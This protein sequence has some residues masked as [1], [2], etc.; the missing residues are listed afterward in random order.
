VRRPEGF[1][2]DL[3]NAIAKEMGLTVDF[4]SQKFDTLIRS[5]RLAERLT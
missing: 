2:V 1:D 5:S 3:A 4:T